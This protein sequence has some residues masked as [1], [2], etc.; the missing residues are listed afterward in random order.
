MTKITE[1]NSQ[2]QYTIA[3]RMYRFLKLAILVIFSSIVLFTYLTTIGVTNGLGFWFLPLT[4]GLLLI[5][6]IIGIIKSLKKNNKV[7]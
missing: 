4:E 5:P 3:T 2:R 7:A 1:E 6:A